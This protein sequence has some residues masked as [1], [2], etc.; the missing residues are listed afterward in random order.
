MDW[1]GEW[2]E[3][4]K[5]LLVIVLLAAVVFLIYLVVSPLLLIQWIIKHF[6]WVLLAIGMLMF[7]AAWFWTVGNYGFEGNGNGEL[8]KIIKEAVR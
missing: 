3:Y 5:S 4:L 8:L 1:F 2:L 7:L 6:R